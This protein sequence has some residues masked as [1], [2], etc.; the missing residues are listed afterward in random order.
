MTQQ[1]IKI[2]PITR[3]EGNAHISLFLEDGKVNDAHFQVT[4]LKGFEK[5]LEGRMVQEMPRYTTRLCGICPVSHHLAAA[6]ATDALFEAPVPPAANLLRE[7]MGVGQ[8]LQSH[9]LHFFFLAAPDFVVGPDAPPEARNLFGLI[10]KDKGLVKNALKMRTVG[11]TIIEKTGGKAVHPVSAIPGGMSHPLS[12]EDRDL[13]LKMTQ[14]IMPAIR[15]TL[16]VGRTLIAKFEDIVGLDRNLQT[17]YLSLVQPSGALNLYDGVLRF[18]R[19]DGMVDADFKGNQYDNFIAERTTD[20][21]YI[22]LPYYSPLGWPNGI[23]R[24]GPLARL[25]V[26]DRIETEYAGEALKE[27]KSVFGSPAHQTFLYNVARLVEMVYANE[28]AAEILQDSQVT[29]THV[30]DPI[31]PKAGHGIGVVEAP[32]GTLIHSYKADHGGKVVRANFIVAT[33]HNN[34]G[35]NLSVK[36]VANSCLSTNMAEQAMLDRVEMVVRAYD[37]C[38][39]CAAHAQGRMP[40][41]LSF[42]EQGKLVRQVYRQ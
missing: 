13:L 19:A 33:T 29:S 6:K 25:N 27:F 40:L 2:K 18:M 21:S 38:L 26:A 42:Y 22:K 9:A 3:I 16:E 31:E 28:R 5:F 17:H 23:Y 34:P 32:R 41:T 36:E 8:L 1:T 20:H 11:Q 37:P 15:K 10:R 4:E 14:D 12:Q 35:I 39:T 24:V 7:L 30:N